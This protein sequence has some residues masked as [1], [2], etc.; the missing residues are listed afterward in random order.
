MTARQVDKKGAQFVRVLRLWTQPRGDESTTM[1]AADTDS[2]TAQS[3]S[4][5]Q[6]NQ[7]WSDATTMTIAS[8]VRNDSDSADSGSGWVSDA[9][10]SDEEPERI[11]FIDLKPKVEETLQ[12]TLER[13]NSSVVNGL[14]IIPG[15][16]CKPLTVSASRIGR[17]LVGNRSLVK[18]KKKWC[19]IIETL[20]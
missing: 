13:F 6:R 5:Q 16:C 19:S 9:E 3:P 4:R 11:G 14:E 10:N 2:T 17:T 12:E 18:D 8:L 1:A 7:R 15:V 20:P